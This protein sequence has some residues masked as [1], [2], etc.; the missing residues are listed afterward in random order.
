MPNSNKVLVCVVANTVRLT[1]SLPALYGKPANTPRHFSNMI[2]ALLVA[3][4]FPMGMTYL[5]QFHKLLFI[6]ARTLS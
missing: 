1:S 4:V 6:I 5:V 3:K 2:A